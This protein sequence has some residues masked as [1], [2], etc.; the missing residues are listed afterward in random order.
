MCPPTSLLMFGEQWVTPIR[1][2]GIRH[3]TG[4]EHIL[5]PLRLRLALGWRSAPH[6]A[7]VGAGVSAGAAAASTST[8]LTTS[9]EPAVWEVLAVSAVSAESEALVVAAGLAALGA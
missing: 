2:S 6:G 4:P 5:G 1:V 7:E 8:E 3:I 9:F